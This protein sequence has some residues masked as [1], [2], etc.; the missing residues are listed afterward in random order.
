MSKARIKYVIEHIHSKR[1]IDG[2]CYWISC[3]TRCRDGKTIT[4]NSECSS[5][6]EGALM[7]ICPDW[8]NIRAVTR[9]LPIREFWK[10]SK[11]FPSY[12]TKSTDWNLT[13]DIKKAFRKMIH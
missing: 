6:T 11:R 1:D 10:R 13:K 12:P 5:N 9:E 7:K 2:N 4:F 3:I 8:R